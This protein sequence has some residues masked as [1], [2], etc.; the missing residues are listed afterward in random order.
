MFLYSKFALKSE[1][2]EEFERRSVAC[3]ERA[4]EA[5][6]GPA[7]YSLGVCYDSGELV[8]FDPVKAAMLFEEASKHGYA[9]A[10]SSHGLHL[11]YGSNGVPKDVAAGMA[12]IRAAADE[13][14]ED[15]IEFLRP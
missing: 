15:A 10:K 4:A 7:P 12:L 6:Y 14:V 8:A 1:T 3:L 2:D 11:F 9:K 5:G 13:R